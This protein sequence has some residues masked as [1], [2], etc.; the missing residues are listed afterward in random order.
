MSIDPRARAAYLTAANIFQR[1]S[2]ELYAAATFFNRHY[3]ERVSMSREM[4]ARRAWLSRLM[5]YHA[6]VISDRDF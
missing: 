5:L 4:A 2:A 6:G 3:P 1:Q